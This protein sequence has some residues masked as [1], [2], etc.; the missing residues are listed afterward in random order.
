MRLKITSNYWQHF[1][2]LNFQ[3]FFLLGK[4]FEVFRSINTSRK[5][6]WPDVY[7]FAINE[8]STSK[9][10]TKHHDC[11]SGILITVTQP[12]LEQSTTIVFHRSLCAPQLNILQ[13]CPWWPFICKGSVCF[14]ISGHCKYLALPVKIWTKKQLTNKLTDCHISN[15][16]L[17]VH[18]K[19]ICLSKRIGTIVL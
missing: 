11:I 14:S 9:S 7:L 3:F 1:S 18:I 12:A 5:K 17:H 19:F 13:I 4:I 6:H 8:W 2:D 10:K 16:F 15:L